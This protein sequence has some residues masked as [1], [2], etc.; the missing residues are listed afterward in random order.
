MKVLLT[1]DDGIMGEGIWALARHLSSVAE[2]IVCA[3][4]HEQSA[5]G[6]AVTLRQALRVQKVRP[7]V[8]GVEAYSVTGTPS[9]AVIL[10]LGK[11]VKGKVDLVISGINEGLN[12]GEDVYISGTVGAALQGYLRG[13]TAMAIS[14]NRE[15][16]NL[17][18]TARIAAVIAQRVA[19]EPRLAG[20]LL[21]VNL[22][23]I[24]EPDIKG[25]RITRLAGES[26]INTVE[27]DS[28][29]WQ[30][31]YWLVRQQVSPAAKNGSDIGAIDQGYIS[32]TLLRIDPSP[33]PPAGALEALRTEV[34]RALSDGHEDGS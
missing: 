20:T 15:I 17:D 13:F 5:I 29:G 26:H 1:N 6:S 28:H 25:V 27:E 24:P 16:R 32:I 14:T 22:P 3:P 4:D 19:G 8:A 30:K 23:D 31:Y 9:D 34:A 21:N 11:L 12:L 33:R 10:A 2:V 7:V 18:S